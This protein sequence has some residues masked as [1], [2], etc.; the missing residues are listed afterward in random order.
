[1]VMRAAQRYVELAESYGITPTELAL[2]W[3]AAQPC[4][5]SILIGTTSVE[6]VGAAHARAARA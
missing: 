4:N 1:M 6:Q 5:T 3:A 2:A